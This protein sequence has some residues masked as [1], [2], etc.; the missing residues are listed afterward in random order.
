M[1]TI[2]RRDLYTKLWSVGISKTAN[3]LTVPYNKL[4]NVCSAHD[5]PLP[6]ASYW[7]SLHMGKEKPTQPLL[8]NPSHNPE[9]FIKEIKAKVTPQKIP[10]INEQ[11][12]TT[13]SNKIV[14]SKS[15][16]P[17]KQKYFSYYTKDE[18]LLL[19]QIYNSLKINKSLS[20]TPHKE[21]V[22]YR[23]KKKDNVSY[24][25]REAKLQINS[26]S[27]VIISETL[28]FV[29]SLFKALEKADAKIKITHDETQILYKNYVF[30][31]N[32]RLPS[33]KVMLSSTDKEYSTYKTFKYVSTGKLNVEVGYY[34]EWNRWHKHEKL[35]KQTKTD[36]FDDL[37]KKVFLY[38]FSLPQKIDE[39]IKAHNIAEEKKRQEE[40][41]KAILKEQHEKEYKLTEE[42]LKRS[43]D[44]FYSQLVKG[45]VMS[46]LDENSDEYNWAMNKA[47]WIKDSN[48]YP[49]AILSTKDKERLIDSKSL[50]GF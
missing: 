42:L 10:S 35:I 21:I 27:G 1:V 32:F 26:S 19:T 41:Q 2:S 44:F 46:E 16:I 33:N 17:S 38:I 3:E 36:T 6:T 14:S 31:L 43:I 8:P 49:D 28:P 24:Y 37:L 11:L 18:Q 45:Y 48:G 12:E 40:E 20:S 13:N 4:K 7:S 34:L 23:Q 29:D 25:E 22:K 9:V 5:I 15:E 39:E 47:D 50:K 30:I